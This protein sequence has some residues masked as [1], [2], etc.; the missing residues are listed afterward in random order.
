ML[1]TYEYSI[2][3]YCHTYV[4]RAFNRV[5]FQYLHYRC[6]RVVFS[7][8]NVKKKHSSVTITALN[9]INVVSF[10]LADVRKIILASSRGSRP[11]PEAS[12]TGRWG[13]KSRGN[14]RESVSVRAY[15]V[16]CFINFFFLFSIRRHHDRDIR[17]GSFGRLV[18]VCARELI[19]IAT[20][21]A[22]RQ[23]RWSHRRGIGHDSPSPALIDPARKTTCSPGPAA[24][25]LL[26]AT[27][28][29]FNLIF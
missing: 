21:P 18:S 5:V 29:V 15:N 20:W 27:A 16:N 26:A 8:V 9:Y 23:R 6:T 10:E 7:V 25:P 19:F 22:R 11:L 17:R 12:Y 24:A 14:S 1:T 13:M 28:K 2:I 4:V 3:F